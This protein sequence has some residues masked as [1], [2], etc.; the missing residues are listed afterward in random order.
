MPR[1]SLG[2]DFVS[3]PI[4]LVVSNQRG[5]VAKTTTTLAVARHLADQGRKVLIVD[6]DPQGSIT[7]LLGLKPTAHLYDFLIK[8]YRFEECLTKA[9]ERI[10]VMCSARDTTDA[11]HLILTQVYR[12]FIF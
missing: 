2:R 7:P 6:T 10:D 12:E 5:G 8:N 1:T 9:H 11:E 3:K 4:K